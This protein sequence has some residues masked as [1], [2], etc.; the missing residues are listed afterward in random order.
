MDDTRPRR[1]GRPAGTPGRVKDRTGER[2]DRL[3]VIRRAEDRPDEE[4][5]G[6]DGTLIGRVQW[7]CA[8]DCGNY[9]TVRAD[10]LGSPATKSCGCS[11]Y[12]RR[13][14][15]YRFK[16]PLPPGRAARNIV[17]ATYRSSARARGLAWELT[18][19]QFDKI[20]SKNCTY[21]GCPPSM[22]KRNPYRNSSE[23]VY[24]GVDRV[25]SAVGY[26]P[27]N[28]VPCCEICNRA[29][30]DMPYDAFVAWIA[31][32]TEYHWFHPDVMPSR[33][34]RKIQESA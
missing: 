22:V 26:T 1:P 23:W 3:V 11:K 13:R 18:S 34:I 7:F 10:Y 8:C 15:L 6:K 4:C 24:T 28:V 21:C 33:M 9:K 12:D 29:K 19:E 17:F 25:E 27:E 31:R 14:T 32:L 30:W 2:Y 5:R 20:T 16:N